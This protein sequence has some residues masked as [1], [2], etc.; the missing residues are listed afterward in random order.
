MKKSLGRWLQRNCSLPTSSGTPGLN[1]SI[2]SCQ[3][4]CDLGIGDK[5]MKEGDVPA[6]TELTHRSADSS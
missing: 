5:I 4:G 6:L 1:L 2:Y 3:G